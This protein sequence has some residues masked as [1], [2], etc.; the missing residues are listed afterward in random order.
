MT[1]E[2]RASCANCGKVEGGEIIKLKTCGACKLVKYCGK[3]C[4]SAHRRRHGKACKKR[5]A[6]LDD[7]ALFR[8]PAKPDECPICRDMLPTKQ[9]GRV[10]MPCCGK[11][12]CSGCRHAHA[13]QSIGSPTGHACA[14]CRAG[15]HSVEEC[16]KMYEQRVEANDADATYG[17]GDIYFKGDNDYGIKKD[18]DKAVELFHRA[19]ELGS[20]PAYR[21]LGF[22]CLTENQDDVLKAKQF[23][24]KGA[25]G[26]CTYSRFILGVDEA[27]LGSFDRAIKHWLIGARFGDIRAVNKIKNSVAEGNAT[28]DHYE[29]ALEGYKQ[30]LEDVRSDLRERAA[31]YSDQYKYLF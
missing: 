17:L 1:D 4:Q 25:I 6:E 10:F 30:H 31:A 15:I 11:I 19:A 29:Q 23:Y 14:F 20:A 18:V 16:M 26:G 28:R 27:N 12:F 24:E 13:L 3:D 21:M 7:E 5:K 2:A 22:V 9:S 8:E